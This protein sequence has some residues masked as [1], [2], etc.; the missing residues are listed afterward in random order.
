MQKRAALAKL[1]SDSSDNLQS[2]S[3]QQDDVG[4]ATTI[5]TP[6]EDDTRPKAGSDAQSC[7]DLRTNS[8]SGDSNSKTPSQPQ[9]CGDEGQNNSDS[10]TQSKNTTFDANE[11]AK[12]H[13]TSFESPEGSSS[14]TEVERDVTDE[15]DS[16][17][18]PS[19]T[20]KNS[21]VT[22]ETNSN[23]T[24]ENVSQTENDSLEP[25]NT[26]TPCIVE[27]TNTELVDVREPNSN[28]ADF[29]D[30]S[31]PTDDT[32]EESNVSVTHFDLHLF[33]KD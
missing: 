19:S 25:E 17:P 32:D 8:V 12:E 7:G 31:A 13:V 14:K 26:S 23:D 33:P 16:P 28:D 18:P 22:L 29:R 24:N 4:D 27:A 21:I 9:S 15:S 10:D 20:Q 5:T 3:D 6:M 1:H 30:D 2:E 11:H